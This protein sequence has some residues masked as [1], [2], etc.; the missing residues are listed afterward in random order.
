MKNVALAIIALILLSCGNDPDEQPSDEFTV[1]VVGTGIDCRLPLIDFSSADSV[2]INLLTGST[3]L[4]YHAFD[5]DSSFSQIGLT[6]NVILR[7]TRDDELFPC[8]TLGPGYPW[9]TILDAEIVN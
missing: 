3:G 7:P 4:R 2:R 8:T 1:N 5:L 9:V 6:L